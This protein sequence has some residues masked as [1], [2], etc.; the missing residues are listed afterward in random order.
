MITDRLHPDDVLFFSE[1]S[2]IMRD[3]AARYELPLKTVSPFPMP[4]KSMAD[5]LGECDAGGN[6]RLV[7]RATV[8]GRWAAGP[9]TPHDV[10][11]TAAHELAH[12]RHMN[13]GAQFQEFEQEMIM[14]VANARSAAIVD[15]AKAAAPPLSQREKLIDKL[16]KM[17]AQQE[18]EG[19]IGQSEA[20]EAFA[21]AISRMM[22]DHVINESEIE[23]ARN[24]DDDPVV[25][26][27]VNLSAFK[28]DSKRTRIAWQEQLAR[29]VS[30][31]H[32]CKFLVRVRSND[33]WF[34]GTRPHAMVAEHAWGTLVRAAQD[35]CKNAYYH[36]G[37]EDYATNGKWK[38]ARP[39]FCESWL[40]AFVQRIQDRL[41]EARLAAVR[42][43]DAA[44]GATSG[45]ALMRLDGALAKAQRYVDDKFKTSRGTT[46]LGG[47]GTTN[48]AG[49]QKG[50]AAADSIGL[51][52]RAVVGSAAQRQLK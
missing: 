46:A 41:Y 17:K 34:V 23:A 27:R 20:A 32:L 26:I 38:A 5:R 39:G 18:S 44:T 14:A 11:R 29:T 3:V 48:V 51:G 16:A 8:N 47:R 22:M 1:I 15:R 24:R 25:E 10:W 45:Q 49:A 7:M 12:L 43:A 2:L 13:H 19:A 6:I 28:I 35:L 31:A 9:R 4:T 52:Q 33:I 42:E 30:K 50:R 40:D 21:T 37:M 36:Y